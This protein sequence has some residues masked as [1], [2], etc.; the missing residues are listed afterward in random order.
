MGGNRVGC[1]WNGRGKG[2]RGRA[3][4]AKEEEE[5]EA[6]ANAR[7][8]TL[9]PLMEKQNEHL[10]SSY[11]R[12]LFLYSGGMKDSERSTVAECLN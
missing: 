7:R 9:L 4:H 8:S 3:V 12:I 6:E 5:D 1:G 2:G 11:Q 10:T